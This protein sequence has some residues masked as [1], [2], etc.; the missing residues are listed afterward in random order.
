MLKCDK[1]KCTGCSLCTL[2]CPKDCIKMVKNE[3]GFLYPSVDRKK[4]I[5]CNL[6]N[7]VC[8]INNINYKV[9]AHKAFALQLK[10]RKI[11]KGCA[12]GGAFTGLAMHF[13]ENGGYVCGVCNKRGKLEFNI[14]NNKE[15]LFEMSGSKYYQCNLSQEIFKKIEKIVKTNKLLFSG[16]PCQA[17]AIKKYLEFK[18]Q[19]KNLF[20]FE[21]LC[22]GVPSSKVVEKYY[23]NLEADTGKKIKKHLF[24]SKDKFV[25]KDYLNKYI[26]EDGS[27]KLY[28]GGEDKLC[29]TFQRQIFLRESCYSCKFASDKRMS[30]F[31]AGDLWEYDLTKK[32]IDFKKG[33]SIL[34]T[35]SEKALEIFQ[36]CNK[37]YS[38]PIEEHLALKNNIP[39][40]KSVKRPI[41]RNYSYKLLN[42]KINFK[43]LTVICCF[44]YYIKQILKRR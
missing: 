23:R 36:V 12:S 37:F 19:E 14:T 16:T 24:R 11:L 25:G 10:D 7:R 4:C 21:I 3:E 5:D 38:E 27:E 42:S 39:F 28:I 6:C 1:K 17:N 18:G 2:I 9:Q 33:V 26:F 32:E 30:D 13:I 22:Q 29:L 8:P 31:I 43:L 35:N 41:C 15:K 44:K 20:T 40:H 34:I